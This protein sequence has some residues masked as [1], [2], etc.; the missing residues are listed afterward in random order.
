M[1]QRLDRVRVVTFAVLITNASAALFLPAVGLW[2]EPE[3]ARQAVGALGIALFSAAQVAVLYTLVTPWIGAR[4]RRWARL[5][6]AGAA[7]A[8]LPL[9]YP[10]GGGWPTWSWLAACIVGLVPVLTGPVL[11]AG[12]SAVTI[13]LALLVTPGPPAD[14]LIITA[15]FGAGLAAINVLHVWLWDMLLQAEQGRAAQARLITAE[16]RLRFARDV[17]DLLGHN[18]SI[19]ALKAEL[20]ERLAAVDSARAGREA[21][22]VRRLAAATLVELRAAVYGYRQ[23]GLREQLAAIERVLDSSGVRCTVTVPDGDLPAQTVLAAVVREATTNVLRHSRAR[24]CTLTIEHAAGV[25]RLTITNDGVPAGAAPDAHSDG[26][27]GLADRLAE[28]GGV[29]RTRA[30][31]GEFTV[32]AAVPSTS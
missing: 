3:P 19:I 21:A 13:A 26:L 20:A 8:S 2:R 24:W 31:D 9:V 27:R 4:A 32:E 18:L 25:V 22:E 1:Q 23:A 7:A 10:V 14:T 16:E 17:H 15:G 5:G 12:L 11:A 28:S 29:L 6:L 30:G